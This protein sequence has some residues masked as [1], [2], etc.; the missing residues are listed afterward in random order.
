MSK[1]I[2]ERFLK[3][4]YEKDDHYFTVYDHYTPNYFRPTIP[5]KFYSRHDTLDLTQA[6]PKLVD[7]IKLAKDKLPRDKYPWPVT[8][9]HNYGWYEPLV[10]LDR[11]DY[12]FYCPA[13]TA[14]F[15]THEILLRLDKTMQKPKFVGIPFKL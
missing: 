8:E 2:T 5:G 12:R 11:N 6:D 15:V 13:K 1:K 3:E 14:P 4:R 9:S 10:P 7:A